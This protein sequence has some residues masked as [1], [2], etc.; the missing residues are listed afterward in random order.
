MGKADLVG[1]VDGVPL[2]IELKTRPEIPED[3]LE[4]Q[5]YALGASKLL[6][7]DEVIVLH[8]YSLDDKTTSKRGDMKKVN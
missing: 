1:R 2:I 8:I 5:L 7:V 4:S 6:K 3:L